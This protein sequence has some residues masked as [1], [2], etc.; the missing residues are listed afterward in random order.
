[1]VRYSIFLLSIVL[2]LP[3]FSSTVN[4]ALE[5]K[6]QSLNAIIAMFNEVS[7]ELV[8]TGSVEHYIC[9]QYDAGTA[10]ERGTTAN[11]AGDFV[12]TAGEIR[13]GQRYMG[14][15]AFDWETA[16]AFAVKISDY[17]RAHFYELKAYHLT[18]YNTAP[19]GVKEEAYSNPA[20]YVIKD[21]KTGE[22]LTIFGW[23]EQDDC[24]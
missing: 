8:R 22:Y 14:I 7:P 24:D 11:L 10:I 4:P 18:R 5:F 19:D 12:L 15:E 13:E 17:V 3:A 20:G 9:G 1:M 2:S 23:L 16:E 6:S 21:Y